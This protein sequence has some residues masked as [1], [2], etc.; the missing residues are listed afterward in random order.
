MKYSPQQ[1]QHILS[2]Y[3]KLLSNFATNTIFILIKAM[4]KSRFVDL[5]TEKLP[6]Y[7]Y[8]SKL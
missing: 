2:K 6:K 3:E 8:I 7:N 1:L 5:P 4:S